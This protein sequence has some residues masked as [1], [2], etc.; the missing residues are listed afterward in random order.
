MTAAGDP[1]AGRLYEHCTVTLT[2][3]QTEGMSQGAEL[4]TACSSTC[5]RSPAKPTLECAFSSAWTSANFLSSSPLLLD[6]STHK[7]KQLA[8]KLPAG[9]L[10]NASAVAVQRPALTSSLMEEVSA[11]ARTPADF[12]KSIKG[13]PVVVK[14]NSGV[15]YR[16]KGCVLVCCLLDKR[17]GEQTQC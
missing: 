12:L 8:S 1:R 9:C 5:L 10:V 4:C 11:S 13:K 7:K 17:C 14:L 3:C 6:A 15:D 2:L 16:G